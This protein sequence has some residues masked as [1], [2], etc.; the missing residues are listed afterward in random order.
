MINRKPQN[1]Q[2]V[3]IDDSVPETA[4][5]PYGR[6]VRAFDKGTRSMLTAKNSRVKW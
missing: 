3:A 5:L 2:L 4:R 6:V 1:I